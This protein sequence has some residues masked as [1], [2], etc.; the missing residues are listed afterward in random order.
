MKPILQAL[1]VADRIYEE[2]NGK[3][4][5][6]GTFNKWIFTKNPPI[7]KINRPDGTEGQVLIGGMQAGAPFAYLSLTDI[8]NGAKLQCQFVNLTK[9]AVLFGTELQITIDNRLEMI[10]VVLPLPMLP[11]TEAGTYALEVLCEN[12]LLGSWKI[13]GIDMDTKKEDE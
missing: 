10:E 5:I 6:A 11:I 9:N 2:K 12:E 8:C 7:Q 3:K 4:I 13:T 1:V